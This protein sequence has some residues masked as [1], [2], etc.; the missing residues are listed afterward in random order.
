MRY[1]TEKDKKVGK[2]L[3][4]KS[5]LNKDENSTLTRFARITIPHIF[6]DEPNVRDVWTVW[7]Q[8]TFIV[9]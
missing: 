3:S 2:E 4:F 9:N 5:N 8:H 6:Q 1:L 7:N